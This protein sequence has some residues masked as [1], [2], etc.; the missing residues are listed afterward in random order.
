MDFGL[1]F[2]PDPPY[3]VLATNDIDFLTFQRLTRFSRYWDILANSGRY[4][5]SL[6]LLLGTNPFDRFLRLSDWL[7][8]QTGQT[9]ALAQE[10]LVNLLHEHMVQFEPSAVD[11]F[12]TALIADYR[13]SGGRSRL[14]FETDTSPLP[15]PRPRKTAGGVPERQARHLQG[16]QRG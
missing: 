15:G 10:R 4:Q 13:H 5:S 6:K 8:E 1:R 12:A 14:A 3:S 9:H 11:T 7:F 2:S 16:A